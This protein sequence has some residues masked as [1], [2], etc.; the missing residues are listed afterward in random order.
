M[1][2]IVKKTNGQYIAGYCI[3]FLEQSKIDTLF[4]STDT[5]YSVEIFDTQ[6]AAV[7]YYGLEKI[8]F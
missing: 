5:G 2:D 1:V 8:N 3:R 4:H 7:E 6:E